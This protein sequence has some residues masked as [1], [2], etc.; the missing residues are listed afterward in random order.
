M[1][2]KKNEREETKMMRGA[3]MIREKKKRGNSQNYKIEYKEEK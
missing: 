2:G 3:K 1:R